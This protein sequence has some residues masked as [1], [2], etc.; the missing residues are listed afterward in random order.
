MHTGPSADDPA[1]RFRPQ[2]EDYLP[3]AP[4][5][6]DYYDPE[7]WLCGAAA[8]DDAATAPSYSEPLPADPYDDTDYTNEYTGGVVAGDEDHAEAGHDGDMLSVLFCNS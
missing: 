2:P 3:P 5:E 7:P 1:P 8:D 6:P 4:Q